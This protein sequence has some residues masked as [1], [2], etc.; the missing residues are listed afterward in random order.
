MREV[1]IS[2]ILFES[3]YSSR[4]D[5]NLKLP[6]LAMDDETSCE[7]YIQNSIP[8]NIRLSLRV[9]MLLSSHDDLHWGVNY[10]D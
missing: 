10:Y 9:E 4:D 2:L 8:L 5:N 3:H 6:I 1:K 7:N